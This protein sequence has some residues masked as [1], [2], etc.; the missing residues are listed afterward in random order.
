MTVNGKMLGSMGKAQT[1]SLMVIP[2]MVNIKVA[3]L[4]VKEFIYGSQ[5][6]CMKE[7]LRMGLNMVLDFGEKTKMI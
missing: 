5:E 7:N 6:V 2:I 1:F 4:V 3:N